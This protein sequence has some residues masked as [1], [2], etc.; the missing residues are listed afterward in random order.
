MAI[1][2]L[3]TQEVIPTLKNIR[4]VIPTFKA[5]EGQLQ[6]SKHQVGYSNIQNIRGYS[7]TQNIIEV[8]PI[9]KTSEGLFQ[10]SQHQRGYS[11][12]QDIR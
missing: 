10:H 8:I 4:E 6:H 12:I 3:K 1:P 2:T 9:F 7:N 11:N 5:S